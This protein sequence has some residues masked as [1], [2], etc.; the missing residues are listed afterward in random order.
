[1]N[2]FCVFKCLYTQFY[3]DLWKF[4][5]H[6]WF[7]TLEEAQVRCRQLMDART[8]EERTPSGV[9]EEV[10]VYVVMEIHDTKPLTDLRAD[11]PYGAAT[12][13]S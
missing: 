1:M 8:D 10:T 12:V 6:S 3:S 7:A 11:S 4:E 9:A 5:N 13:H 2:K